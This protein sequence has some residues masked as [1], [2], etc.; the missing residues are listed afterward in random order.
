MTDKERIEKSIE[1]INLTLME[2]IGV[3]EREALKQELRYYKKIL[4]KIS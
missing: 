4:K 3:E 2:D 1:I